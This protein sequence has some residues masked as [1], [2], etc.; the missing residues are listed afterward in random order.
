LFPPAKA[1]RSPFF[2]DFLVFE[3][4]TNYGLMP[5]NIPEEQRAQVHWGTSLKTAVKDL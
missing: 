1:A 4:G 2:L 3:D 5:H